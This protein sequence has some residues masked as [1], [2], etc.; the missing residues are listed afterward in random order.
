[1]CRTDEH[2]P[3]A[4]RA[5]RWQS[6]LNGI[7]GSTLISA[8]TVSAGRMIGL[9]LRDNQC[10]FIPEFITEL[11]FAAFHIFAFRNYP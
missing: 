9:V 5:F 1:M 8:F 10:R 11:P 7:L 4:F 3:V 2:I 6:V